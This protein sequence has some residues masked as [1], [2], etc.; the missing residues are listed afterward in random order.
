VKLPSSPPE[1]NK[2]ERKVE[3]SLSANGTLSATINEQSVGQAAAEKRGAYKALSG[4]DFTKLIEQW[5]GRDA[6]G[7]QFSRIQPTDNLTEGRFSLDLAFTAERY[8]QSMQNRLLVFKTI[9]LDRDEIP[10]LGAAT[11]K[12]PLLLKGSTVVESTHIKFPEGFDLDEI[13]SPLRLSTPYASYSATV[14][15]EPGG[16][17]ITRTMVLQTFAVPPENYAEARSFFSRIRSHEQ[18]AIVLARK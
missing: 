11:R 17:S 13:V 7:A 14:T 3:L 5:A 12:Y 8:A 6:S 15:R 16:V 1:R 9:A 4:S 2:R 10:V 18:S